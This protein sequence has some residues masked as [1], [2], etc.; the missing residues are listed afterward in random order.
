MRQCR[1]QSIA[2]GGDTAAADGNILKALDEYNYCA[3]SRKWI[4]P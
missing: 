2:A 1:E 4:N 3:F